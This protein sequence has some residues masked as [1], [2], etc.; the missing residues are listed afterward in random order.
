[1]AAVVATIHERGA[2]PWPAVEAAVKF[3][4]LLRDLGVPC[5]TD[6]RPCKLGK[7][8]EQAEALGALFVVL[9]GAR[10]AAGGTVMLNVQ[11]PVE[12]AGGGV[13]SGKSEVPAGDAAVTVGR[14]VL[15]WGG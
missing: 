2:D 14:A 6:V 1:M 7:K 13:A 15:P 9:I 12:L 8:F 4:R 11:E 5:V 3:A 10:E